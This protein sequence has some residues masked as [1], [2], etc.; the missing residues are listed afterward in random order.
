MEPVCANLKLFFCQW[1]SGSFLD[2]FFRICQTNM[3]ITFINLDS[4]IIME[5]NCLRHIHL[6]RYSG[7]LHWNWPTRLNFYQTSLNKYLLIVEEEEE[8][9]TL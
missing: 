1:F 9:E 2:I 6:I 8:E 4:I 3:Q 5:Y 7:I